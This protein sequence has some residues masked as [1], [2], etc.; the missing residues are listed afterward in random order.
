MHLSPIRA[1][2]L[3]LLTATIWGLAFIA[4]REAMLKDIDPLMFNAVRFALGTFTV[5][6][7]LAVMKRSGPRNREQR[8]RLFGG[9]ILLGGV[10]ALGM[11]LQQIGL[12][13]TEAG[14]AGFITGLYIVFTPLVGLAIGIK[15]TRA[16]WVGIVFAMVGLWFLFIKQG[17]DGTLHL[18]SSDVLILLSAIM[19]AIQV[20]IIGKLAPNTD[21]IELALNQFAWA[22]AFSF[23]GVIIF[24]GIPSVAGMQEIFTT[25]PLEVLYAGVLA[26]GVAFFLQ[27]VAQRKSPPS[28]VAI[29]L[30][31]EAPIAAIGGF[32]ILSERY[33]GREIL[34]CGLMLAGVLISQAPRLFSKRGG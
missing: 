31:L 22:A 1:D 30:G 25:A 24:S 8:R 2:L 11:A 14:P 33:G 27:I 28:H 32:L 16:T 26:I 6:P 29:I 10:V 34:G 4:Q 19:W 17:N 12:I 15:T 7:L 18:Q 23:I 13:H 20:Q 3:L 9:G 21:P 5:L